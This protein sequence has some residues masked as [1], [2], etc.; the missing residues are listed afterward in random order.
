MR[1]SRSCSIT[2][3]GVPDGAVVVSRAPL[4]LRREVKADLLACRDHVRT[5]GCMRG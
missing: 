5:H 4:F 1:C 3:P 2:G